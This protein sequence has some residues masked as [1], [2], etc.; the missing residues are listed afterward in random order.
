[1]RGG[2]EKGSGMHKP[3]CF[4]VLACIALSFFDFSAKALAEQ[5]STD[6]N[7]TLRLQVRRVPVDVVVQDKNGNP[8]RGLKK[9]DFIVKEDGKEQR[10]LTFEWVDGTKAAA[11]P[12]RPELP[13]N[14]FINIP[15]Q[16]EHGPLYVLYYDMVNTVLG[17]QMSFQYQLLDF[18]DHAPA[19]TRIAL[20]VNAKGLHL[21]QGFT[22]DRALL[23]EAILRRGDG[24][25]MPNVFI[26]GENYGAADAGAALSNLNFLAEYLEGLPGRKNLLWLASYFP[27]PV[28]PIPTAHGYNNVPSHSG[29]IEVLD[30][31][32]L[33]KDNMRRTYASLM[34]SQTA[35]YP[36]NLQGVTDTLPEFDRME[37]I[38]EA[39]GGRALYGNNRIESLM[40]QATQHGESYYTLSYAPSNSNFDGSER[41]IRIQFAR[42]G[43]YKLT[44]RHVYYALSDEV[45]QKQKGDPLRERFLKAK[46]ADTLYANIEQGAPM[47][48]DLLF[49]AHL[50]ASG[51]PHMAT[52]EEM[53]GLENSPVYFST[54]KRHQNKALTPVK[55]QKY[56]IDYGVVDPPL[57]ATIKGRQGLPVL[58]FA[59][60]AYDNE[61]RLL[62]GMLNE[63]AASG[64]LVAKT[65]ALF[66]AIQELEVPPGAAFIRLAVRDTQTNRTGTLEVSLPLKPENTVAS[67]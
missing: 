31:G 9:S 1:M 41:T 39:T 61:G 13:P 6:Q 11:L 56:V 67:R 54:R 12:K 47:L 52:A 32:I 23:R 50:S 45:S 64:Q 28:A 15:A 44:Y 21:L 40:H 19:G 27:L 37:M 24:P 5:N 59:A 17:D 65:S 33:L 60:A 20:F 57:R 49:S 8:V 7:P 46:A 10:V 48:H 29:S 55:L 16:P 3:T 58:E 2:A 43:D 4:F 62:N 35:L 53:Q 63:G 66:H 18:V 38:A 25:H 26:Y 34:R 30:L 42:K 14:T 22:T 36:V 51:G